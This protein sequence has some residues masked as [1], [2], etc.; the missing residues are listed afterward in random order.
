MSRC[1]GLLLA[2]VACIVCA[3][4]PASSLAAGDA[5]DAAATRAYL[6]ASYAYE[7]GTKAGLGAR[8]AAFEARASEIAAECPSALVYAPRDEAFSELGEEIITVV[9]YAGAASARALPVRYAG[10][11]GRLRWSNP[12]VTRLVRRRAAEE[13]GAATI[14]L[15]DVCADIAAWK[16]NAYAV[17][18]Q[19]ASAFLARS[20]A[21][22]A[23]LFVGPSEEEREAAI[24]RLLRPY[25]SPA[26]RTIAKR[27]ERLEAQLRK[28][29]YSVVS[30]VG[31]KLESALGTSTL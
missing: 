3:W 31:A 21:I 13:R 29:V 23:E 27:L 10:E 4:A 14:T 24:L 5:R 20:E 8:A 28:P 16:A 22:E 17:L 9:V 11:V 12:R 2:C 1:R 19:S 6:R 26:D 30:I 7:L 18:P 25:E 15:P